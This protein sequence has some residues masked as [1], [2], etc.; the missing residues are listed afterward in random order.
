MMAWVVD[1]PVRAMLTSSLNV[2]DALPF[3][4]VTPPDV[5]VMAILP[6]RESP[7]SAMVKSPST[8]ELTFTNPA[9]VELPVAEIVNRS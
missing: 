2:A 6:A 4:R 8:P 7:V 1:V 9:N 5:D 3:V